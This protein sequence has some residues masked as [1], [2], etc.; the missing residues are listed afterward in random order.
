MTTAPINILRTSAEELAE[1]YEKH[2]HG[3]SE[4]ELARQTEPL[5]RLEVAPKAFQFRNREDWNGAKE[6][7]VRKLVQALERQER[8]FDPLLLYAVDGHR[9]VLDGHC[10]LQAYLRAGLGASAQ[11]PVRYFRGEFSEALTQPASQNSKEKLPL[12]QEERLEAAW[13]L[14]LFDER[15]G[16]YS[17]RYIERATGAGKSTAGNMRNILRN[18]DELSFDPRNRTWKEV[19]R[20]MQEERDTDPEWKENRTKA[21]AQ[22]IRSQLGDKPNDTPQ[23]IFEALELGYPQLFPQAIPRCWFEDSGLSNELREEIE[24]FEF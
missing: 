3:L 8:L 4:E 2:G 21:W 24:E 12:T 20:G 22:R 7:H 5:G 19:K 14:V 15:R 6:R 10:R 11:I 9:L 18:D 16:N 1:L 23:C 13:R 17:L